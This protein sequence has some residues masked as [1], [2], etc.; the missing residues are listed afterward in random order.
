MDKQL[1]NVLVLLKEFGPISKKDQRF[2]VADFNT[3]VR[4]G[5]AK[6]TLRGW[7]VTKEGTQKIER[8]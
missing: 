3:L 2:N 1:R 5:Y 6:K 4:L 8:S 7:A